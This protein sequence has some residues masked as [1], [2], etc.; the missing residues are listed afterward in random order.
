[1][2]FLRRFRHADSLRRVC[3]FERNNL[4]A[5]KP[6][7]RN[8]FPDSWFPDSSYFFLNTSTAFQASSGGCCSYSSAR[9][10]VIPSP[11]VA[12]RNLSLLVSHARSVNSK[13]CLD[14]ARHDKAKG[15][16][17][18][19][20]KPGRR[21]S[22]PGFLVS[23][24]GSFLLK[25]LNCVPGFVGRL[26]FVFERAIEIHLGQQIVRIKFEKARE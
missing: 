25:Y 10:S 19:A 21:N 6:G 14:F 13:R 7:R 1:M 23:R 4:E 11:A 2:K 17:L 5:M 18:E 3:K 15:I 22:F 8:S 9:D 16:N 20:M 26:L 12:G 24:F